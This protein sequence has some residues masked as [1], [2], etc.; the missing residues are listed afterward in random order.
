MKGKPH[1]KTLEF[2]KIQLENS[3][4]LIPPEIY[5]KICHT[6]IL[7]VKITYEEEVFT[8]KIDKK[9]DY[10]K[11]LKNIAPGLEVDENLFRLRGICRYQTDEEA[12]EEY[13]KYIAEKGMK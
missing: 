10:C 8:A 2:E 12:K 6:K 3:K 4:L 11:M 13:H 5:K 9:N 1:M 7:N